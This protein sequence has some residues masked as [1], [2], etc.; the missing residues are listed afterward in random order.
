MGANIDNLCVCVC[1]HLAAL[2]YRDLQ[3]LCKRIRHKGQDE[4]L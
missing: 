4:I 3:L 1:A 2:K